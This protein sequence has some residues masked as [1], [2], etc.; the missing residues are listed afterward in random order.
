MRLR[1]RLMKLVAG[2]DTDGTEVTESLVCIEYLDAKYPDSGVKLLPA[3]AAH[4]AKVGGHATFQSQAFAD[5]EGPCVTT[6]YQAHTQA[7]C[8]S[9]ARYSE[10]AVTR[11]P[12]CL[13][14]FSSPTSP[15]ASL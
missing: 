5:H 12:G 14:S 7:C 10:R 15:S 13:Q 1:L 9:Q 2:A 3:N 8:M 6:E 4:A 11:R